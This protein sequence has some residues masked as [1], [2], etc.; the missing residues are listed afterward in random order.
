M[1]FSYF[2]AFT[3]WCRST[4]YLT[5]H[6]KASLTAYFIRNIS[7]KKYQNPYMC[8]SYS[9]PKVGHFFDT[10]CTQ[11]FDTVGLVTVMAE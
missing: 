2:P 5:W 10:R 11:C 3:K 6:S 7:A 4:N 8:Q 1:Q 9:K